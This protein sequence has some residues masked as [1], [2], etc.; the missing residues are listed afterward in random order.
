MQANCCSTRCSG[1]RASNQTGGFRQPTIGWRPIARAA[2]LL[3]ESIVRKSLK[4]AR[5]RTSMA[6]HGSRLISLGLTLAKVRLRLF[7]P[8]NRKR[9]HESH[10][11]N[12][13]AALRETEAS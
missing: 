1:P 13:L 11:R 7:H 5:M 12:V 3:Y 9:K 4:E 8:A 10:Q 2:P 6:H